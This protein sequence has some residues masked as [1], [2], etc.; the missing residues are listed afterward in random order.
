MRQGE[1]PAWLGPA[2]SCAT[3][4][5]AGTAVA[6]VHR[7]STYFLNPRMGICLLFVLNR[8]V[9]LHSEQ[10]HMIWLQTGLCQ[11]CPPR[12]TSAISDA[13][14]PSSHSSCAAGEAQWHCGGLSWL[15]WAC[16]PDRLPA[17]GLPALPPVC[18]T[19]PECVFTLPLGCP[20]GHFHHGG[21]PSFPL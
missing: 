7:G 12:T 16:G 14:L 3:R 17:G 10:G 21:T 13:L 9:K 20:V 1:Q 18:A 4:Q 19:S 8:Q 5:Q 2:G 11:G 15:L 6:C